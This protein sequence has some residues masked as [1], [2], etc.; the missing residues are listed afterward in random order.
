[1]TFYDESA[2]DELR[3][4]WI[5]DQVRNDNWPEPSGPIYPASPTQ[6]ATNKLTPPVITKLCQHDDI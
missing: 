4:H 6:I 1:M 5:P 2:W 3:S